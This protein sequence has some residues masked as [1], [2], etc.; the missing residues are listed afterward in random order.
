MNEKDILQCL[1]ILSK[2]RW[3][4]G[5]LIEE[6]RGAFDHMWQANQILKVER[7]DLIDELLTEI[8]QRSDTVL[9]SFYED[10]FHEW[11]VER[12][13]RNETKL[14]V[15]CTHLDALLATCRRVKALEFFKNYA[16]RDYMVPV[17]LVTAQRSLIKK[18]NFPIEQVWSMGDME[19]P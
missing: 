17:L 8:L 19:S 12:I 1:E 4:V 7:I 11:L 2:K 3:K 10:D 6:E 18:A 15:I 13:K 16:V 5:L 14:P 9:G